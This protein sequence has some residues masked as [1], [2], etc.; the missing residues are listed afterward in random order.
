M[1][2]LLLLKKLKPEIPAAFEFST[3]ITSYA[4]A[5]ENCCV[6]DDPENFPSGPA[7]IYPVK[8]GLVALSEVPQALPVETAR[9][10]PG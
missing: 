6:L 8:T 9:P 5:P 2:A 7:D 4:P 3:S 1:L 10:A